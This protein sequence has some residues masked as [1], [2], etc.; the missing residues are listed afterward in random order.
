MVAVLAEREIASALLSSSEA[1]VS[2][3]TNGSINP[4][5]EIREYVNDLGKVA[6]VS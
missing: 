5:D 6:L 2:F 1:S 3:S 4:F